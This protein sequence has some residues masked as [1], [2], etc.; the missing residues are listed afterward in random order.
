VALSFQGE[1]SNLSEEPISTA[2]RPQGLPG[3]FLVQPEPTRTGS[4]QF[5]N[6]LSHLSQRLQ[7]PNATIL[8]RAILTPEEWINDSY[9]SGPLK[10][11]AW[12]QKVIDFIATAGG[13]TTEVIVT[14]CIGWGK[15]WLMKAICAY[16]IYRLSCLK[17][18]QHTLGV[19]AAETLVMVLVSMNV[20]KARAKLLT[21][22]RT[23]LELTPYFREEFRF[24]NRK[25]TILDFPKNIRVVSG[26]T[27]ESAVHSEDVIFLGVSEC[28]FLPVVQNSKKK[29][30]IDTLDVAADLVEATIRRMKSRFQQGE[31]IIPMCRL[32]LD[33]SRQYPDDYLERRIKE[34]NTN[35][36]G[37][38]AVVVSRSIWEAKRGVINANGDPYFSGDTFPVAIGSE[39][40]FSRILDPSE[41]PYVKGQVIDIPAEL[42]EEFERDIEGALRDFAGVAVM[43]LKPLITNR[44]ALMECIRDASSYPEY[45]CNHPFSA[46]STTLQDSVRLLEGFLVDPKTNRLRINPNI[47]R[48]VHVDVGLT[49][50]C[51]GFAM[52]HVEEIVS[53]TRGAAG[54]EADLACTSCKREKI[55]SCAR[56]SGKG[57]VKHFGHRVKCSQ[58]LGKGYTTCAA[59][60]GTGRYGVTVQR[61]RIY[62]DLMLQ[63]VP[64]ENSQ[65]QF[66]DVEAL[67]TK[68]RQLGFNIPVVTADGYNSDQFLQRQVTHYGARFA[69]K[70]SVDRPKDAYL[71]LRDALYDRDENDRPRLTFYTYD[72]F[73]REITNVE[74][75]PD[76]VDHPPKGSKDV[77]DAV[78]GVVYNCERLPALQVT[79]DGDSVSVRTF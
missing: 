31:G 69:K 43:S 39:H 67:L 73:I 55:Q 11:E 21:P 79:P 20:T 17:N 76:K 45:T 29:R 33:S 59:C 16:D 30:G 25:E 5:A 64:P 44:G 6:A 40:L 34:I 24:D 27:G 19:G 4:D 12:P 2:A 49:T 9:Y 18:P 38:N 65:I 36:I 68:L 56:C 26:V 74:D 61:P 72:P 48:A 14:G 75:R 1:A 10:R 15:S 77:S 47:P 66:D 8:E 70:L 23:M 46:S 7:A 54:A 71:S 51:L 78:A 57:Q 52:G 41:V 58:C 32:V 42:R 35:S 60:G 50:D 3:E 22:L 53:I 13:D 63:V 37:H 28:N 62:L